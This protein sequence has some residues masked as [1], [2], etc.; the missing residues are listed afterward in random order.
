MK[1]M[2]LANVI[3]LALIL[4]RRLR[5]KSPFAA[6]RF[7][8]AER[9]SHSSPPLFLATALVTV[10]FTQLPLG[11]AAAA[12]T[13]A[14]TSLPVY[15]VV[16]TGATASQAAILAR[17]LGISSN[18]ILSAGG[19]ISFVD[20]TGYLSVPTAK[21]IKSPLLTQA[22]AATRNKDGTRKITPTI[23]N[24]RAIADLHVPSKS[25]VLSKTASALAAAGLTPQ[26]A[27]A[28]VGHNELSLYSH[29]GMHIQNSSPLDTEVAYHFID[30]NGYPIY[31]PG[32]QVQITYGAA[33]HVSRVLYAARRL[34]AVATVQLISQAEA[35]AQI[36]RLLPKNATIT[37]RLVYY[38]PPLSSAGNPRV[39]TLIPWYAYYGTTY[40][41]NPQTGA[42]SSM[43]KSKVKSK[44][45]FIPATSDARFVPAANFS[46]SG[47]RQVH[48]SVSVS[49]GTPPYRYLWAGSDPALSQN[50]GPS[51][52]Y[53][54]QFRAAESLLL[55]P[56]FNLSR[57]ESLSVTVTD[58]N[59]ININQSQ[60]VPVQ[61]TPVFPEGHD[62]SMPTYGS[63]NP[64]DPL[65]WEPARVAWNTEMATPGAGATLSNDW[66]GDD[67]WPGDFIRPT[68][69][70]MLVATPWVYG[71]ADYA[72]WGVDTA[73]IVLDNADGWSDGTVLMQPGAP[74]TDYAT[75]SIAT[76]VSAP[77]VSINGN[78]FGVPASHT[79]N[80]D[81]SWGPVGPNDT[82]EWLLL[83]DCD[84]LD[85]LDGSNLNVAERWGPAFDGLHVLTGFASEGYGD[86]PFEGGVA[87]DVLGINGP[88]Q[89]IVQSWFSSAAA[90]GAG[91]AAAMGPAL[92]VAPDAYACDFYDYFWRKGLVGP[93]IV[94]SSYPAEDLAYW[95]LTSTTPIQYLF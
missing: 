56:Y 66:L 29:D 65:H 21:A 61:A 54:P 7:L 5:M 94:P 76:P 48:A 32:A 58:A 86:G 31:G 26:F 80:Y 4:E 41:A 84:M 57:N 64:G 12:P 45:G 1:V 81:G 24:A 90:T 69:A 39:A 79:V 44:I 35:N 82:L 53:T 36:A 75:A 92:E 89:T 33:G 73:D 87:D 2:G 77:D 62:V 17:Q 37:S 28:F 11:V 63:E 38:A 83:D 20:S 8:L 72:N 22:I 6:L 60:T 27:A 13:P 9:R 55:N 34:K 18:G 46:A 49:G 15:E 43:V 47:G 71:D 25:S 67:A 40:V 59:G 74:A 23:L 52:S 70:G 50:T 93:T 95:Y 68:P 16:K 42:A 19:A 88:A 91:T 14:P 51:I 78:G 3:A 85:P 10:L 30:P